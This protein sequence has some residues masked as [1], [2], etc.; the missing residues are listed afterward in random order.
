MTRVVAGDRP[1]I[2]RGA[3]RPGRSRR[4]R[5]SAA[6]HDL[7]KCQLVDATAVAQLLNFS[8][9]TLRRQKGLSIS[10]VDAR[11]GIVWPAQNHPA[12]F[13][14]FGRASV[15]HARPIRLGV[16]A[17][18]NVGRRSDCVRSP[19]MRSSSFSAISFRT[20]S[21]SSPSF[22]I[23]LFYRPG[24]RPLAMDQ[25]DLTARAISVLQFRK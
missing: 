12:R 23:R 2:R 19:P 3:G 9:A 22:S 6:R 21:S 16:R 25:T 13:P 18:G 4:R 14:K 10:T 5:C 17:S 8:R 15:G 11:L 24:E 7:S 20:T 1:V